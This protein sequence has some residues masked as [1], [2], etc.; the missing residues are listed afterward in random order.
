MKSFNLI[1]TT[2]GRPELK[3]MLDSIV[4]QMEKQA[5][6]TI[7]S[8]AGHHETDDVISQYDFPCTLIRISNSEKLGYWGH[9]SRNKYQNLLPGDYLLNGDDD[10]Y[11][12]PEAMKNIREN[13]IENKL[14][15]FRI[16]AERVYWTDDFLKTPEYQRQFRGNVDTGCGVFPRIPVGNLKLL[17]EWPYFHGGDGA[18]YH[19]LAKLLSVEFVDKII[20]HRS[21]SHI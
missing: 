14:Y 1:L 7:I 10:N 18:F 12:A 9:G 21:E 16:Q 20:Y 15:L 6:I 5:Y 19:E 2:I 3:T 8:D 17:P 13:C 11:Y 4:H